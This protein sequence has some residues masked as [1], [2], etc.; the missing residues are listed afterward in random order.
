MTKKYKDI[1]RK[2]RL[3]QPL[4]AP[5]G[6]IWVCPMCGKTAEHR[7]DSIGQATPGWDEACMLNCV[8]VETANIVRDTSTGLVVK[9]IEEPERKDNADRDDSK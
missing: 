2:H 5:E 9:V 8:L 1:P 3:N 4:Q 7:Y 6:M